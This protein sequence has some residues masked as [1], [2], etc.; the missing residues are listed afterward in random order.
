MVSSDVS[1]R[2][3]HNLFTIDVYSSFAYY[4]ITFQLHRSKHNFLN[5]ATHFSFLL[6]LSTQNIIT[7]NASYSG[8]DAYT[9]KQILYK[10][11]STARAVEFTALAHFLL[12]NCLAIRI[13]ELR[14]SSLGS[15]SRVS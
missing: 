2:L 8:L 4:Q 12:F 11:L 5:I 3:K 14:S 13:I 6:P 10:G 9:T 7:E 15:L 1:N